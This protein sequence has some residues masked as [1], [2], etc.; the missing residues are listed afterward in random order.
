VIFN[1]EK[2]NIITIYYIYFGEK[3]KFDMNKF[4]I[5]YFQEIKNFINI[6]CHN[7][8]ANMLSHIGIIKESET[9]YIIKDNYEMF[10][11]VNRY[12][13]LLIVIYCKVF[14]YHEEVVVSDSFKKYLNENATVNISIVYLNGLRNYT[15]LE[16]NIFRFDNDYNWKTY[17]ALV[18]N[19]FYFKF[20]GFKIK[21]DG[22]DEINPNFEKIKKKMNF[23]FPLKYFIYLYTDRI[24]NLPIQQINQIIKFDEHLRKKLEIF[25]GNPYC[26]QNFNYK[27]VHDS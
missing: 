15:C 20:F 14:I 23:L 16:E 21:D 18:M 25:C 19:I 24:V 5:N 17:N 1:I 27:M 13:S 2:D 22:F 8:I 10:Q 26:F 6:P 9:S 3:I 4:H 12:V 11:L 7:L